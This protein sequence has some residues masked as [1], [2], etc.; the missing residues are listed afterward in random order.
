MELAVYPL[1]KLKRN[2]SKTPIEKEGIEGFTSD[3]LLYGCV[4]MQGRRPYME[5]THLIETKKGGDHIF[6]IFDGH[7][8]SAVAQYCKDNWM[9]ILTN[10][11]FY[12]T[13]LCKAI[14]QTF[15][16][17]ENELTDC[18]YTGTTATCVIIRN[19]YLYVGHVGDSKVV[20]FQRDSFT[21]EIIGKQAITKDHR[22]TDAHEYLRLRKANMIVDSTARV[23]SNDGNLSLAMS[24]ALGDSGFKNKSLPLEEQGVSCKPDVVSYVLDGSFSIMLA[25]DGIWDY[26]SEEHI[27]L[28][29]NEYLR[30]LKEHNLP[31]VL[32]QFISSLMDYCMRQKRAEDNMTCILIDFESL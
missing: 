16:D 31:L 8:G 5:D 1:L 21:Y 10:N 26:I 12:E 3:R 22:P 24:R 20:L 27:A 15:F 28:R 30:M 14:E 19:N 18:Y 25:S 23:L 17:I 11:E 29:F 2:A 6:C 9:R 4:A 13:D 7:G 32:S